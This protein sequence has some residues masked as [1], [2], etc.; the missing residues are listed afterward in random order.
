MTKDSIERLLRFGAYFFFSE[1]ENDASEICFFKEDIDTILKSRTKKVH[2]TKHGQYTFSNASFNLTTPHKKRNEASTNSIDIDD[3]EFWKKILGDKAV[4]S[5]ALAKG[6]D[7]KNNASSTRQRGTKR[8][9]YSEQ[10]YFDK[11]LGTSDAM[12]K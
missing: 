7:E 6:P 8:I 12:D 10:M 9:N 5:D 4:N 11:I 2:S 3:P 1:E